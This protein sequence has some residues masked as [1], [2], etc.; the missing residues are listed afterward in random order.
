MVKDPLDS[1]L[2]PHCHQ[3]ICYSFQFAARDLLYALFHRQDST[4]Y[5]HWLTIHEALAERGIS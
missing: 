5:G 3:L 2:E 4:Y 1:E